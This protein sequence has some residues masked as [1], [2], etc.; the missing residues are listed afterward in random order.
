MVVSGV[1]MPDVTGEIA[2]TPPA[3]PPPAGAGSLPA[4]RVP[5]EMLE[6]FV[7]SVEQELAGFGNTPQG[8]LRRRRGASGRYGVD[9][10]VAGAC[11]RFNSSQRRRRR[12]WEICCGQCAGNARGHVI[13]RGA[14]AGVLKIENGFCRFNCEIPKLLGFFAIPPIPPQD[15]SLTGTQ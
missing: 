11:Q 9:P 13:V 1:L 5:L 3:G 4:P 6:A 15:V 10:L 8:R 12:C 14:R 7:A 2:A